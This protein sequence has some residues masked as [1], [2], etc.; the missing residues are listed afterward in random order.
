MILR[1]PCLPPGWYPRGKD[2]IA[3]FLEPFSVKNRTQS[4]TGQEAS[5]Y[6]AGIAPHAGW[7]YSGFTAA[8]AVSGLDKRAETIAV[9]GGHLPG[10][11]PILVAGED[12]VKTPF[13]I[14]KIDGELREEFKKQIPSGL[15]SVRPDRYQDNTVEVLLPMVRY[16]FP[17]S[18]LLWLRFPS[19]LSSHEAGKILAETAGS[20]NRRIAVIGSTD[21]T[22]Y[23]SNYGFS[24]KGR[25]RAALEWVKNTND[26]AFISAVLDGK[27]PQILKRAEED[28]SSCSAGAVLGALG[29]ASTMAE[30]RG[31]P[32]VRRLLD[33]RTSAGDDPEPPDSFVGYASIVFS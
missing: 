10:G 16:F 30:A 5:G 2:Q 29:F 7:Y 25:G 9:I 14:L 21:L 17:E 24:P 6:T 1:E 8:M 3:E 27:A 4:Q 22:H 31:R 15:N 20:L 28:F 33:Y 12:G 13:G 32:S 18:G 11:S 26:A 23:G 19:D